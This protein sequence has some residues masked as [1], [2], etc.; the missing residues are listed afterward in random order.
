MH[1]IG[2]YIH[3]PFCNGKCP[4]CDF[5]SVMINSKL[6]DNY[7]SAVCKAITKYSKKVSR[8]VDTVYLGGGTPNLLG[9][10]NIAAI[11]NSIKENFD[12]LNP[13]ITMEVNPT[14]GNLDFT[15]LHS[16][17]VNRLS[18]GL[19]SS[20]LN[21]L[22]LLGRKHS[23]DDV[24][25]TISRAICAGIDNI[26]LDLMLCIPEQSTESLLHSIEF[27][28]R[29]NIQHVSAYML[30]IEKNTPYFFSRDKLQLKGE[31]EQSDIYLL[32][33]EEL[34]KCGFKQ[35]EISNFSIPGFESKHNLKY[36]NCNEYLGIGPSAHSFIN[37]KRFYYPRSIEK[38]LAL[39]EPIFDCNG[40]DVDE[41]L[42]L[43]LR[44]NRGIIKDDFDKRFGFSLPAKYFDNAKKY[45][46][47]G[48]VNVGADS[49]KLTRKGFLV[50]NSL[51]SKILFS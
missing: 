24:V 9:E 28:A 40:G 12:L 44:L 10:K 32:A 19:Q 46:K 5:Y 36:W 15:L 51:I 42:M 7:T 48:L 47:Y 22:K 45:E 35:Y 38:F 41:F 6:A 2:L 30:K 50:S 27:C 16:A 39:E 14:C 20:N 1:P 29:Q 34:E 49:I 37:G 31:D 8:P 33:C 43:Q 21:E 4:Y 3:I 23:S 11:L 26:S 18:V 17:G 13:E 25:K